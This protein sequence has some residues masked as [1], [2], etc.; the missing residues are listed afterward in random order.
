MCCAAVA[1]FL[2]ANCHVLMTRRFLQI[3]RPAAGSASPQDRIRQEVM[4][5]RSLTWGR[6]HA[7]VR[8]TDKQAP[9]A[10]CVQ[11]A[12]SI[13]MH[14]GKGLGALPMAVPAL[15][16]CVSAAGR[17]VALKSMLPCFLG[18]EDATINAAGRL[19][20]R[21]KLARHAGQS[22]AGR[23]GRCRSLPAQTQQKAFRPGP[24]GSRASEDDG[25]SKD[26]H[27]SFPQPGGLAERQA[28]SGRRDPR[29]SDDCRSSR[30]TREIQPWCDDRLHCY[31]AACLEC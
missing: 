1:R 7:L 11:A 26:F 28:C 2:C 30:V 31:A 19:R 24:M 14:E 4:A 15:L 12:T 16:E 8:C 25:Q 5:Q 29:Q 3:A 27:C 21:A 10:V 18:C 20:A 13:H 22:S 17:G 23:A 6:Y 9:T